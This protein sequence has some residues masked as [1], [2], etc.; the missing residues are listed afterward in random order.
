VLR[1][2]RFIAASLC[3]IYE[4]RL[5]CQGQTWQDWRRYYSEKVFGGVV[6]LFKS[7]FIGALE[8]GFVYAVYFT[9][10]ER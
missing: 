9:G 5:L 4:N 8:F 1:N 2:A 10:E 7:C 3:Q 6:F